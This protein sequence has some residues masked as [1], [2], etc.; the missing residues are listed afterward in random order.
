MNISTKRKRGVE[1]ERER[2]RERENDDESD[3]LCGKNIQGWL[4]GLRIAFEI[5]PCA[6]FYN[7]LRSIPEVSRMF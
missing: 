6:S 5:M 7:V 1:H 3:I 2:E 4:G